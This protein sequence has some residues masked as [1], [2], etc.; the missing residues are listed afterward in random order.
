MLRAGGPLTVQMGRT[1]HVVGASRVIA[2]LTLSELEQHLAKAADLLRGSIDQADF[3]AYIF[4]LMFFKRISDVY[5]EEYEAALDES[6]GDHEYASFAENHRFTIPE[7]CLW[8]DVRERTENVGQALVTAFREIE[9]ASPDTLYGIFGNAAWTNKDKLPDA[10]LRDLMEHF[11][12]RPLTNAAVAP[13]VFGQAY[14]YLIKR[15]ADQ[16]NKKAGEYYTPRPVVGLLVNILDPREGETVYDP[17][18]GT[19]GMLIEVIEHVKA[20]GGRAERLWGRLFGQEKV[21]ATSSIARMNLLLHGIGD[22]RIVKGDTLREPAFY[23]GDRLAQFD[24]VIANPPFSLKKWGD[25]KWAS[26]QWGRNRLGGV[27]PGG[28]ADWAWVQHMVTSAA[29]G[30]GRVA[31]VLP[32]G[33]LFRQGAEARIR[34]FMLQAD[35][36][37]AV[38]GLAPNL[39]Y[40]TGLAA[41]VLVLRRAKPDATRGKVLFVNGEGLFKRGRSQNTL[42]SEH[43]EALLRAYRAFAD[44]PGF[45]HVAT[46]EEIKG[47]DHNLNIPLYV[48]PASP[49]EQVTL[50]Q[51]L[52]DL[53]AAQANAAR[54]RAALEA[55]LAKWGLT[56]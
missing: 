49:A 50:R 9:K 36:V 46:A 1:V 29:A 25:E 55:E 24:C 40:G 33:A 2:P 18:C 27:P 22:F 4:P 42:E 21:L 13:D 51:A 17:A 44:E 41:C 48:E 11:S 31:V 47:N 12:T 38:I 3:K 20:S 15:F 35:L 8:D 23:N 6:G 43:A 19:G 54:T 52:A 26:D 30:S 32:Q 5:Q 56:A 16:S 10:K 37:E 45:A 39:F 53:E 14:E 28:Y 7:G 34:R